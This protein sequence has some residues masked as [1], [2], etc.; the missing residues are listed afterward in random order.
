MDLILA[1]HFALKV[2]MLWN[3]FTL[4]GTHGPM[5]L[6]A[7]MR[8][9]GAPRTSQAGWIEGGE[10]RTLRIGAITECRL[11]K[12]EL[13][14]GNVPRCDPIATTPLLRLN[15]GRKAFWLVLGVMTAHVSLI[16]IPHLFTLRAQLQNLGGLVTKRTLFHRKVLLINFWLAACCFEIM[17]S[18]LDL[19][20]FVS[21]KSIFNQNQ[22]MWLIKNWIC[23]HNHARNV[24]WIWCHKKTTSVNEKPDT[25]FFVRSEFYF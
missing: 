12:Y 18:M 6:W 25:A 19:R 22:S 10:R 3:F 21:Q 13:T 23:M 17:R 11:C 8:R 9:V 2:S 24:K 15:E 20:K 4:L 5:T 16:T 14:L 1:K 7:E